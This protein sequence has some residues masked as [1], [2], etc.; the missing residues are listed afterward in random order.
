MGLLQIFIFGDPAFGMNIARAEQI[1]AAL[2][3]FRDYADIASTTPDML[4]QAAIFDAAEY[5]FDNLERRRHDVQRLGALYM[6]L[7]KG[8]VDLDA[9][10]A[11][12]VAGD[13]G[14]DLRPDRRA[15]VVHVV[16]SSAVRRDPLPARPASE[17]LSPITKYQHLH[18]AAKAAAQKAGASQARDGSK[19]E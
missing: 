13:I 15:G 8:G 16:R 2:R 5:G 1:D 19:A 3:K 18:L 7:T 17:Q 6:A 10:K 9:L 4:A 11:E 12:I 14:F